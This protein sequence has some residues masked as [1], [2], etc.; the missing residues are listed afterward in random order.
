[1]VL[2]DDTKTRIYIIDECSNKYIM[3]ELSEKCEITALPLAA[4]CY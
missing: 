4:Q 1:M 2:L 3:N